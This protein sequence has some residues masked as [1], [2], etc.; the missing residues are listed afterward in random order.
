M[1]LKK[2]EF[3]QL[4]KLHL[5]KYRIYDQSSIKNANIDLVTDSTLNEI[6]FNLK[7]SLHVIFQYH[8]RNKRILFIGAPPKLESKIN[9]STSHAAVSQ[10]INVQG[11]ISNRSSDSLMNIKQSNKQAF[12]Q[13][14]P[15]LPKLAKKP[16]LIVVIAHEKAEAIN[17]ECV[18]AKLP[19][20][21]FKS[22][23][24]SKE[25]WS[26]YSYDLQLNSRNSSLI[27]DKNLLSISL[28]FLF[29]TSGVLNKKPVN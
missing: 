18:V 11:F 25:I 23:N 21:N 10:N 14:K 3:K 7:K 17:K 19:I 13:L 22:E 9:R 1:K 27:D 29:K 28:N 15:L 20:I 24:I 16:D 8:T 26:S 4:L 2:L 5:L 12:S 6:I